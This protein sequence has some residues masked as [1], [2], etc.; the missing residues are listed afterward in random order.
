MALPD[1]IGVPSSSLC[2]DKVASGPDLDRA[3]GNYGVAAA[4]KRKMVA[5][6]D[7]DARNMKV[8]RSLP[9]QPN[10]S[11]ITSPHPHPDPH[12]TGIEI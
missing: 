11:P 5:C 4:I 2:T 12:A 6:D 10:P 3:S 9:L 1:N 8:F 7:L